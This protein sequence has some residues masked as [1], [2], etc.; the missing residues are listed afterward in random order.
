L[1]TGPGGGGDP[2]ITGA[3]KKKEK[4]GTEKKRVK[5]KISKRGKP[6]LKERAPN[7]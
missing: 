3:G 5:R 1:R 7:W 4:K 2:K 6:N